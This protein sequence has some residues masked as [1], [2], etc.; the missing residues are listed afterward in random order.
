MLP[1]DNQLKSLMKK[2]KKNAEKKYEAKQSVNVKIDEV[3][4][5]PES[6]QIFQEMKKLPFTE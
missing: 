3:L 2:I 5:N 4:D 6:L 1:N